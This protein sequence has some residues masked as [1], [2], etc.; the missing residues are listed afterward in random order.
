MRVSWIDLT[1]VHDHRG[2]LAAGQRPDEIPFAPIRFFV[3][4][5]SSAGTIRGGHAHRECHQLLVCPSGAVEV[6]YEDLDG[7]GE[8]Q[9]TSPDAALYIPP[10]VWAE[11]RYVTVGAT[12]VVLASHAYDAADYVDD[13]SEALRLRRAARSYDVPTDRGNEPSRTA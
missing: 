8:V 5:D 2:S 1:V 13:P 7:L 6:R 12:L 3:V 10:L 9:L 4:S 11:Q